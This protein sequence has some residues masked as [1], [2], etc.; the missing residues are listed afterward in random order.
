MLIM[1]NP[2]KKIQQ[3]SDQVGTKLAPSWHQVMSHANPHE[4]NELIDYLILNL[5]QACPKLKNRTEN[6]GGLPNRRRLNDF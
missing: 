6:L 4:N 1:D 3:C 2:Y 5:S